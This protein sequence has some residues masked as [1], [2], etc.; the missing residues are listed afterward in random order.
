MNWAWMMGLDQSWQSSPLLVVLGAAAAGIAALVLLVALLR[1]DKSFANSVLAILTL[2]SIGVLAATALRGPGPEANVTA[3]TSEPNQL[4]SPAL[5][6][7]DDL[8]GETVLTACEKKLFGSPDTVAAAVAE[9]SA[10]VARLTALGDV[11]G[12]GKAMTPEI[13]RLRRSI[14]RDRYGLVAYVLASRDACQPDQCPAFKSLTDSKQIAANIEERTY[15]ALLM[16][17]A[18]TWEAPTTAIAPPT[19]VIPA[20]PVVPGLAGLP[21]TVPT[22]KPTTADFPTAASIPPVNIMTPE[23]AAP[24]AAARPPA[25]ASPQPSPPSAANAQLPPRTANSS[26][27][28]PAKQAPKQ[29][30]KPP[31]TKSRPAAP[32]QIAPNDG[33][34]DN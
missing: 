30:A 18:P 23:P 9:M 1:A 34:P 15:E 5:A 28:A 4:A 12:A 14:E 19:A 26:A 31:A 22:G 27:Q 17:Y 32:V 10:R 29:P 21:P 7:L 2:L 16:R 20:A 33:D 11:A 24:T 25:A 8:A 6:C 3:R 13:E